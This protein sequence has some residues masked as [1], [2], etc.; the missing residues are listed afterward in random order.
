MSSTPKFL[1]GETVARVMDGAE[2]KVISVSEWDGGWAYAV[3]LGRTPMEG[4]ESDVWSGS[5]NAWR[6][7][8]THAHVYTTSQDCD[9]KYER[10]HV[11][12]PSAI[13]R[14]EEF[15]DLHFKERVLG[16]TVSLH[17][18]NGTLTVYPGGMFWSQQTDEGYVHT[19]VVWCNKDYCDDDTTFRDHTAERAG[20]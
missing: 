3:D 17:A 16:N 11:D 12:R 9:G 4:L 18:E 1:V 10:S 8:Q 6:S 15:G 2:G 7:T 5:E 14:T 13:E 20:Y 19:Q